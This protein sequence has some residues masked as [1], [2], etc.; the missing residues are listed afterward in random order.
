MFATPKIYIYSDS[1]NEWYKIN[2][3]AIKTTKMEDIG[4]AFGV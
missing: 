2:I 3:Y 4:F 1:C